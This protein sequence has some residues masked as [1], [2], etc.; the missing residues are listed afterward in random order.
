MDK[1][2]VVILNYNGW[3]F[4]E[5]FLPGVIQHSPGASIYVA[6][7]LSTDQSV[8]FL[9]RDFPSVNLI[10]LTSNN[11]YAGGYNRALR[12][13]KAKYYVLLN[14][15]I[16][17][18]ANWLDPIIDF[19]EA[20]QDVAACQP[21]ILDYHRKNHFEYAGA[22][23][24]FIDRLGY[25]YCRG[26]VFDTLERDQGQHDSN[27]QVFWAS[28]ACL[29]VRSDDFHKM[30]GFDEHFFAHMEEIDLCWRLNMSG[31]RIH[32]IP[33]SKVY[34]V[35]GGTLS[36]SNPRKTYLNFRN[37]LTMIYKNTPAVALLWKL[38]L[39]FLLDITAA[40]K[41]WKDNSFKH[42]VAVAKAYFHF[43]RNLAQN[44]RKRNTLS[45]LRKNKPSQPLSNFF[46]P[47][48]YYLLGKKKYSQL[49]K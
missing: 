49:H 32:C 5:K 18:A 8:E 48:K 43:I 4:L 22:A 10:E 42:F 41:F 27:L 44:N 37:H 19:M 12:Q 16:E 26:R 21:K 2:A 24:G 6:D 17:V 14:S 25:P 29:F 31:K 20:D 7:N 3:H 28:G 35:G 15:D 34:H 40:F 38:P 13:I 30:N 23:G 9:I 36:K 33:E 46:I 11:G 1:V 47:V 39:K 45:L